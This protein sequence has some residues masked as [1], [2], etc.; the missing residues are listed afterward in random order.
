MTIVLDASVSLKWV[1]SE[2]GSDKAI[3]LRNDYHNAATKLIAPDIF[4]VENLHA[5]TKAERQRRI[6]QGSAHPLWKSIFADCPLLHPHIP[7]LDRACEIAS[8]TRIGIYDC[9]YVALAEREN[10]EL[11]T[12][13]DKLVNNV[14]KQF[15]FV[16]HMSSLW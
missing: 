16:R 4:L 15:L 9:L 14:Q 10:C 6:A 13:D 12:A 5:L 7:L 2:D 11:V 8:V 1:I 3:R